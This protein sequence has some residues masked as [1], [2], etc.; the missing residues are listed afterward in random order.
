MT[1]K[2]TITTEAV[3]EESTHASDQTQ[4]KPAG[5]SSRWRRPVSI[6][7]LVLVIGLAI[8]TPARAQFLDV[9][10]QLFGT[11]QDD[12]GSSL[13]AINQIT[14]QTQKLYQTTM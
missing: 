13:S 14:Q 4:T 3:I 8:P 7:S 12:M 11:I 5:K 1:D 6:A 2:E 9:F 10:K